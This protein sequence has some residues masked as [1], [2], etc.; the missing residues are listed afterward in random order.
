MSKHLSLI[1]SAQGVL[2]VN[3]VVE[4]RPG[5]ID[6]DADGKT[7]YKLIYS[8]IMSLFAEQNKLQFAVPGG[9]IGVGISC[10]KFAFDG[11]VRPPIFNELNTKV[12]HTTTGQSCL[13]DREPSLDSATVSN[14]SMDPSLSRSDM[15]VG[16]VLGDVGTLPEHDV[17]IYKYLWNSSALSHLY[18]DA[19]YITHFPP[20]VA[21]ILSIAWH[22]SLVVGCDGR[23]LL[24]TCFPD[25]KPSFEQTNSRPIIE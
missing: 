23:P 19:A 25:R 17:L 3:Q 1:S 20:F 22:P 8:R 18:G 6:K 16:Q 9:L 7:I 4:L 21:A 11:E 24:F 10:W 2:K 12:P 5:I 15:L 13:K 14:T